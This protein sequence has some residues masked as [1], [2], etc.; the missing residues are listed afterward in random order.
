MTARQMFLVCVLF[1]S[2]VPKIVSAVDSQELKF[3]FYTDRM[4]LSTQTLLLDEILNKKVTEIGDK[5]VK[6][7]G[8]SDMSYTFR[9]MNDNTI[10]AF[11]AAGG[12]IYINTGLL[13][14]LESEDELAAVIAHELVHTNNSH[15]IKFVHAAHQR[16]V[17]GEAA[18]ILIAVAIA[19]AGASAAGPAPAPTSPSYSSYNQLSSQIGQMSYDVGRALGGTMSTYMIKGYGKKQE[20]EADSLAIGYI[21]KAGYDPKAMVSVFKKLISARD[22]LGIK[23]DYTSGLINAE[24]G[25]EERLKQAEKNISTAT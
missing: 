11:S 24:P 20:L 15:Q 19:A 1:F 25:L 16:E 6:A 18:G 14:L 12:F 22:K 9:I 10:N 4:L 17:A 3:G 21:R 2:M 13:E 7:S 8:Q 23:Q 5:V